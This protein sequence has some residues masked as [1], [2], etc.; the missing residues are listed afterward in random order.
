MRA[1]GP[2]R[3]NAAFRGR[4]GRFALDAGLSVPGTGVTAIFGPSGCGKT[5]VA[6][7]IAGLQ[8]LSDGFCAIDGEVWQDGETFRPAHR[9][10]VGYV[11]QEPSL[12]PHLSVRRN[13][14]Y[15]A[16]KTPDAPI[17]F[18][19]VVELLGITALLDRSPHRLSGGERQR[20]AIGRALLSQPKLLLMDEPLAALDRATKDEILP[21]LERLHDR[22]SLPVLYISHDM[23]EIE[24]FADHLVLM[25]RGRVVATGPLHVLQSDP[26]L[27]LA[28]SRDAAVSIDGVVEAYD[29]RYGLLTLAVSGGLLQVPS[30]R[31]AVGARQRLR[32][33]A[34]DVSIVR[35]RPTESSI[36]NILPARVVAQ[37]P[38]GAGEVTMV[39]RLGPDGSGASILS[40]ISRRSRDLLG[41]SDGI[42]VYAQVKGVSLVRASDR[43]IG[44]IAPP[45]PERLDHCSTQDTGVPSETRTTAMPIDF[46]EI[47]PNRVAAILYRPQDDLDALLADFAQD[48]VRTGERIGGIVQRNIKDGGGCQVGMQ[49]IDLMTG[50]EISICQPLGSGAMACKLDAAGLA[51]ASVAVASA[52]AQNVDLIVINKFS[53]QEAAGQGLRDELADAIAAGIPVL[54]AVPEKCL[55]AWISFTGG[56]GTTL[57]CERQVI[58]AWWQDISSRMKRMRED[59][60]AVST[61]DRATICRSLHPTT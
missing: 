2:G 36:L 59:N 21:F 6:R 56:I 48:L 20:V 49:A 61:T 33:A 52:I 30:H 53:K 8:R 27:P 10:P 57:L 14:L 25:E 45:A 40:R 17:D 26:A 42:D 44:N 43:A 9:R 51:D 12:F 5:T 4:L 16:P 13:L 15:G 18:D 3:I 47:D 29:E 37:S 58:E 38:L 11:F 19:E 35:T 55:E 60:D 32:I 23:A 7:C 54:T 28:H 41:L 46:A 1:I 50:R 39:I 34:S 22:L 24:R 31:I